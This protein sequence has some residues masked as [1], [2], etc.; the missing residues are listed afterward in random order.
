MNVVRTNSSHQDFR[1]LVELLDKDLA[2]SDGDDHAFYDQFNGLGDIKHAVVLY[3]ND[4]AVSCGA[5]KA[6]DENR[7]EIK[8]MYTKPAHRGKRYAQEVL[9]ELEQWASAEG[10]NACVLE[11]GKQQPMAIR[12]YERYGYT[13]IENYGQYTGVENSVCFEKVLGRNLSSL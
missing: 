2:V 12:L 4:E 8:R 13:R 6:F 10:F 1:T 5:F 7:V 11:T 3:E 9:C